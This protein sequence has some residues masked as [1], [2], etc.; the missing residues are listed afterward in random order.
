[1]AH[2]WYSTQLFQST[3][4]KETVCLQYLQA[5]TNNKWQLEFNIS[6]LKHIF[7]RLKHFNT[8]IVRM[9]N[10]N[11]INKQQQHT[12]T[13]VYVTLTRSAI[14]AIARCTI[15]ISTARAHVQREMVS[16]S[17][18]CCATLILVLCYALIVVVKLYTFS[19]YFAFCSITFCY[20]KYAE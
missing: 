14:D 10:N 4:L 19:L 11:K 5:P 12:Y 1:M 13:Y 17:R 16:V 15:L 3:N 8:L 2:T 9:F 18:F 7:A 20:S 6:Q